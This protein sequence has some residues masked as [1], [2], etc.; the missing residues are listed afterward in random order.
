[1]ASKNTSD[2]KGSKKRDSAEAA[3]QS[4]TENAGAS[5][6]HELEETAASLRLERP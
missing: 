6:R 3:Q 5:V 2:A 4:T 1:M